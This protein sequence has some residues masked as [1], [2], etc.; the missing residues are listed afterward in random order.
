MPAGSRRTSTD[1][2][3]LGVRPHHAAQSGTWIIR[4]LRP[5]LPAGS[6]RT[7]TDNGASK[8]KCGGQMGD[9]PEIS[10]GPVNPKHSTM[11]ALP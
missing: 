2:G 11:N 8:N 9:V 10:L 3:G 1:T 6:R 5:Y 4:R 7:S